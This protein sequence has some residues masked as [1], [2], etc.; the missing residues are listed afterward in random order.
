ME[1]WSDLILKD[2]NARC[3][4]IFS[5]FYLSCYHRYIVLWTIFRVHENFSVHI[6]SF[7]FIIL[8]LCLT[9]LSKNDTMYC[10]MNVIN[11]VKLCYKITSTWSISSSFKNSIKWYFCKF[12]AIF[13]FCMIFQSLSNLLKVY[14]ESISDLKLNLLDYD[15]SNNNKIR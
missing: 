3:R 4:L 6:T 7:L 9:S 1:F 2:K 13:W 5:I 8:K 12:S 10:G 15:Q 14:V 11:V